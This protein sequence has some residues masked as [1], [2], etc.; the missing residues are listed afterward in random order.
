MN[1]NEFGIAL[2][3]ATGFGVYAQSGEQN[4]DAEVVHTDFGPAPFTIDIEK[5]TLHN[6]HFRTAL[7]TGEHLQLTLMCIQPGHDIGLEQH[8]GIDQFLRIEQGTGLCQM[9]DSKD[10]L[11][12]EQPIF[13]NSAIFVPAGTWHNVTNTGHEPMRLYSIYG[14]PDHPH[15]D[16]VD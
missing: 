10:H 5:A 9:G 6:D 13:E 8:I 1:V 14:P 12:F 4:Y 16:V 11:Y 3:T 2:G 15:G 7:W